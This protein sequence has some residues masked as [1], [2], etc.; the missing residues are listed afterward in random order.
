[1]MLFLLLKEKR[2]N[3][4]SLRKV[5]SIYRPSIGLD[6]ADKKLTGISSLM[7]IIIPPPC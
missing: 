5:S 3:Q 1:M 6:L 2:N 7:N 4:F